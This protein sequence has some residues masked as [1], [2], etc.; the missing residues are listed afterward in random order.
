MST[1][2]SSICESHLCFADQALTL[3]P[4]PAS[5]VPTAQHEQPRLV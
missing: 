2:T 3:S 5:K 1:T 4:T